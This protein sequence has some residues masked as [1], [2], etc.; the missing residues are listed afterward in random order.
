MND[1]E[2]GLNLMEVKIK[3]SDDENKVDITLI[4]YDMFED[5][6]SMATYKEFNDKVKDYGLNLLSRAGKEVVEKILDN[7]EYLISLSMTHDKNYER[8]YMHFNLNKELNEI[9]ET[10][11]DQELIEIILKRYYELVLSDMFKLQER[12]EKEEKQKSNS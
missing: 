9:A 2:K 10:E 6:N 5:E 8:I 3:R 7:G 11:E 1:L 12:L 4:E